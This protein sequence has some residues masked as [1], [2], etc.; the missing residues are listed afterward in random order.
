ME[1]MLMSNNARLSSLRNIWLFCLILCFV[2]LL[3]SFGIKSFS[4]DSA[5]IETEEKL[6]KD[7]AE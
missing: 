6:T 5:E 4:I 3:A 1:I 7:E 2:M